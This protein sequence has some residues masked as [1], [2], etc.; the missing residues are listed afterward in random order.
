MLARRMQRSGL[1]I[2][3]KKRQGSGL[4]AVEQVHS[5]PMKGQSIE[6]VVPEESRTKAGHKGGKLGLDPSRHQELG[7]AL[8]GQAWTGCDYVGT[9]LWPGLEIFYMA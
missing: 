5:P 3:T 9:Q 7:T 8:C 2:N 6:Y 4:K 1:S